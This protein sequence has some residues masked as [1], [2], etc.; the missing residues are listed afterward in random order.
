M[1]RRECL[2]LKVL[3]LVKL[4]ASVTTRTLKRKYVIAMLIF[5]GRE[6][7]RERERESCVTCFYLLTNYRRTQQD[8]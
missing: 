3:S 2:T 4:T 1:I 6:G 7:Q 8:V 5:S